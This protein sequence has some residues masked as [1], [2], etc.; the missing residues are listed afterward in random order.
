MNKYDARGKPCPEPVL[1]TKKAFENETAKFMVV[2]GSQNSK[3][4]ISKFLI[5]FDAVFVL[6]Q[7]VDGFYF[8]IEP[9]T[10]PINVAD[11]DIKC[12]IN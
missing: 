4:N 3:E 6:S 5:K 2:C 9:R 1:I 7:K 12:S 11:N 8:E 10:T